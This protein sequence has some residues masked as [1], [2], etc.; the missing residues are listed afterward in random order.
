MQNSLTRYVVDYVFIT[1]LNILTWA[2][3]AWYRERMK[4][5]PLREREKCDTRVVDVN[6]FKFAVS[7]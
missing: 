5:S 4:K 2:A 7:C 1:I 6:G 3:S